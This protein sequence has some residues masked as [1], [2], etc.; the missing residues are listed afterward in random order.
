ML[1]TADALDNNPNIINKEYQEYIRPWFRI[2]N[3]DV[4]TLSDEAL[5]W[6]ERQDY[7]Y[8]STIM[9]IAVVRTIPCAWYQNGDITNCSLIFEHNIDK[10][11]RYAMQFLRKI[12]YLLRNGLTK[13]EVYTELGDIFSDR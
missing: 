11:E 13:D 9:G 1:A 5:E 12:I 4:V 3:D 7:N 2:V 6:V 10:E 8:N